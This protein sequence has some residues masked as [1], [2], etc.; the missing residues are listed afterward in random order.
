VVHT[1]YDNGAC[2]FILDKAPYS[3]NFKFKLSNVGPCR[4]SPVQGEVQDKE[5]SRQSSAI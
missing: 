3:I 4:M 1:R 5:D 2:C